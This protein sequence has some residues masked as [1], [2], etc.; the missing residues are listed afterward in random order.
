MRRLRGVF[1]SRRHYRRRS[2][3]GSGRVLIN[4]FLWTESL[5]RRGAR[6]DILIVTESARV[7]SSLGVDVRIEQMGEKREVT[8]V[9]N[10]QFYEAWARVMTND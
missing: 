9:K 4:I 1:E 10:L 8:M 2:R 7:N 6:A 3:R 5:G